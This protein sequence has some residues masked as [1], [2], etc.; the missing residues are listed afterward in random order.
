MS[1]LTYFTTVLLKLNCLMDE[2]KAKKIGEREVSKTKKNY[3]V[4]LG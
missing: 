4:R 2:R 3:G 1:H